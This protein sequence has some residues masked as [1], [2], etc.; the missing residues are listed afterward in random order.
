MPYPLLWLVTSL[1]LQ[2]ME[3]LS[4]FNQAD[5]AFSVNKVSQF[6]HCP[7]DIHLKAV[8]WILRYLKGTTAYGMNFNRSSN[9]SLVGF[10]DSN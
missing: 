6:M 7:L 1:F 3:T 9:L 4:L 8:K 5:I 2:N 10:L